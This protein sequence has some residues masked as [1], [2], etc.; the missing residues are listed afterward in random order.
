MD[1]KAHWRC[2]LMTQ[3]STGLLKHLEMLNFKE[4]LNFISNWSKLWLHKFN[5]LKCTMIH[6]S[7]GDHNTY[8]PT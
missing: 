2:L 7:K 6:L 8:N 4:D 1:S 3:N 5:T